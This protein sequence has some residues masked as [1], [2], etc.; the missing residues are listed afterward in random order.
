MAA[1]LSIS[2]GTVRKPVE[3]IYRKLRVRNKIPA[4]Q[5]GKN[6]VCSDC[7]FSFFSSILFLVFPDLRDGF[8]LFWL[9]I[10]EILL[11]RFYWRLTDFS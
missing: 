7:N 2:G 5:A 1:N 3:H 4:I 11:G 8:L 6:G 9:C 10:C